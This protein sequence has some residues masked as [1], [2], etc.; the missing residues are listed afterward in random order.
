MTYTEADAFVAVFN[1]DIDKLNEIVV[2]AIPSLEIIR[3]LLPA[4]RK[5]PDFI[6]DYLLD[7]L[8][9]TPD[10]QIGLLI[11]EVAKSENP[12]FIK[13]YHKLLLEK[14][15]IRYT[16]YFSGYQCP[17]PEIMYAY[18]DFYK[19][20]DHQLALKYAHKVYSLGDKKTCGF[21]YSHYKTSDPYSANIFLKDGLDHNQPECFFLKY[22]NETNRA[23]ALHYLQK[24]ADYDYDP[25]KQELAQQSFLTRLAA[26][27]L[28]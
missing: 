4:L 5:G 14:G 16:C 27:F 24:A 28:Y 9:T 2:F 21:L 18:H 13:R 19:S 17:D 25:A 23:K 1:Q 12:D 8:I 3:G 11:L 10:P 7:C 20:R 6:K 26:R 15:L 22:Q